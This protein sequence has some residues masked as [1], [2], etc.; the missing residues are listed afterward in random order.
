MKFILLPNLL[1]SL[2]LFAAESVAQ[3][4]PQKTSQAQT[5]D[6]Q[7]TENGFQPNNIEVSADVPVTLKITRTTDKT[8]ATEI[9]IKDK[10]INQKLPLNKTV[11]VELGK[12][13]KGDLNFSCGMNMDKGK[14]ISK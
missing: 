3:K 2:N 12:I 14:I 11:V 5:I 6:I 1:L 10:K 4:S 13:K 7:V 8:C 9:L